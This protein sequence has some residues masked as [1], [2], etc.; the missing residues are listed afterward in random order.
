MEKDSTFQ[1]FDEFT[2]DIFNEP[3]DGYDEPN[4]DEP[5]FPAG[6]EPI[7]KEEFP[8][9]EDNG[10]GL[11]AE[12]NAIVDKNENGVSVGQYEEIYQQEKDLPD[13]L[14]DTDETQPQSS[15]DGFDPNKETG[16]VI[17]RT[18]SKETIETI[19][20]FIGGYTMLVEEI[21]K[22]TKSLRFANLEPIR[23]YDKDVTDIQAVIKEKQQQVDKLDNEIADL[24]EKGEDSSKAESEKAELEKEI[25]KQKDSMYKK[26]KEKMGLKKTV[27]AKPKEEKSFKQTLIKVAIVGVIIAGFFAVMG[28]S[29]VNYCYS[30]GKQAPSAFGAMFGWLG[31]GDMPFDLSVIDIDIMLTI[32]GIVLGAYALVA[33]FILLEAD[34]KKRSRVGHEHGSARLGTSSDFKKFQKRFMERGE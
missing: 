8:D 6:E 13:E 23:C 12:L 15:G 14:P 19:Q 7:Y 10:T 5:E 18:P 9:E 17:E 2:D 27:F 20:K 25:K 29:Y 3:E 28:Q 26:V 32:F 21:D 16:F 24:I 30:T 11:F 31:A 1:T 33:T 34:T 4:E 22:H